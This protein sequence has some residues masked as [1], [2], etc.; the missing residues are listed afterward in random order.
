M[1]KRKNEISKKKNNLENI[2]NTEKFRKIVKMNKFQ[3]WKF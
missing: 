3:K 1:E 2:Y